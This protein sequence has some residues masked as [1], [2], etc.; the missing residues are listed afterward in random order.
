MAM[1]SQPVKRRSVAGVVILSVVTLGI[2]WFYLLYQ[3]TKE[4]NG[5]IG[6]DKFRPRQI[7]LLSIFT[8][9]IAGAIVECIFALELGKV[10]EDKEIRHRTAYLV[11]VVVG[12]NAAAWF[13]GLGIPWQ[14]GHEG[15]YV[16]GML[17]GI[18][19][20]ALVQIELNKFADQRPRTPFT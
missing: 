11:V 16:A 13:V 2:Y 10:A 7:V 8:L 19:A 1:M 17:A 14:R 5:L 3:W 4:V 6:N 12:L 15:T 9:G 20:T 18:A